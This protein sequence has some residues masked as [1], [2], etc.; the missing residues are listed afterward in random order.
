VSSEIVNRPCCRK[1]FDHPHV[2]GLAGVPDRYIEPQQ[3]II[4]HGF[5]D[6]LA[7]FPLFFWLQT[8]L[9]QV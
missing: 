2:D 8:D 9:I 6:L 3:L 5:F 4:S 1:Q 7:K